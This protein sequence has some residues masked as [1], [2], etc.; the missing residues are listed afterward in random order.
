MVKHIDEITVLSSSMGVQE[1]CP[2][3]YLSA[4]KLG[5]LGEIARIWDLKA[6]AW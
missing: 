6:K 2:L 1:K 5:A 4:I 3:F